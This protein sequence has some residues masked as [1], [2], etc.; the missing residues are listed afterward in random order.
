VTRDSIISEVMS[1]LYQIKTTNGYA[2]T[3]KYVFQNPEDEPLVDAMPCINLFEFP[4][5][6]L[7]GT[8]NRGASSPPIYTKEFKIVLESWY[9]SATRANTSKDITTF[10]KYNRKVLFSDGINLG[11][12]C[13]LLEE[14]EVSRVYRPPIGNNVVGIGQVLTI[15]YVEDFNAL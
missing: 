8:K 5:V 1:R 13:A 10:L 14:S 7:E 4:E 2:F 12:L 6:T 9:S 11:R 3:V 15:R